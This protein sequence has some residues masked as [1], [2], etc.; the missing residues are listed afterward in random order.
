MIR[1]SR[2][3]ASAKSQFKMKDYGADRCG[4]PSSYI[5]GN[6]KKQN[7]KSYDVWVSMLT[8]CYSWKYHA[9]FP[10]YK[11]CSVCDEWKRYD[12]FKLWHEKNYIEGFYLDK[13][14]LINGN[15]IYSPKTCRYIPQSLNNLLTDRGRERGDCPQG[16]CHH[17]KRFIARISKHGKS[18]GLGLFD[19]KE[20][21]AKA[22][23]LAKEAHVKDEAN[24]YFTNGDIDMSI[25]HSLMKWKLCK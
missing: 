5:G 20:L 16:V 23:K 25:Y 7:F 12:N 1:G 22:Y 14:I 4:L 19:T 6:G 18:E 24:R 9:R 8:R 21:A 2:M 3:T 13:D 10:T 17:E 11:G 15:K